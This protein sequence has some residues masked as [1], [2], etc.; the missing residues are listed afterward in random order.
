MNKF[1]FLMLGLFG[2]MGCG[3][4][5]KEGDAMRRVMQK[6]K[7]KLHTERTTIRGLFLLACRRRKGAIFFPN[8]SQHPALPCQII[9]I[10]REWEDDRE[11][12]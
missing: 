3:K 9:S 10:M 2:C 12:R 8:G 6:H 7:K 4:A 11:E 5:T 1:F